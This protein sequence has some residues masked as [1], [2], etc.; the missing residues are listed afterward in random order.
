MTL[1]I[2][3]LG[4]DTYSLWNEYVKQHPDSTICHLAEWEDI[5]SSVF[6]YK[7]YYF[8]ASR[9]DRICG[10]LP[11]AHVKTM[12]FGNMLISTPCCVYGGVCVDDEIT[13]KK[14]EDRA[15][16][17][18]KSL[19]VDYLELRQQS[20]DTQG[21]PYKNLYHTFVKDIDA[22]PEKNYKSIPRKQ[23]AMIRKGIDNGLYSTVD[24]DIDRFYNIYSTSVRNLGTPVLQKQY[25]K[26][27]FEIFG[28]GCN[29]LTIEKDGKPISSVFSFLY[30]NTVLPYY[31]GGLPQ[32]REYK[33]HDFMYWELMRRSCESGISRFDFGRSIEGTGSFA[34]KKH[35]GFKPTP[36]YYR[37]WLVK[38]RKTPDLRPDN[39]RYRLYVNI[40]KKLPLVIANSIGP[41]IARGLI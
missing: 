35:W 8:F 29:V 18:A 10:I 3:P 37:Q 40:W 36:L 28:D 19:C 6:K 9:N 16:D 23:R 12:L 34:F 15:I 38:A 14:L 24:T 26:S 27:L 13:R 5:L 32:A 30:N 21:W 17:L 22:D 20:P 25:F 2:Q 41:R 7:T 11:L 1:T 33:A 4:K 31:G 39:P